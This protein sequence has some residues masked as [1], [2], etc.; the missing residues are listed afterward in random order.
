MYLI[1]IYHVLYT[2]T[3]S[4]DW[5]H[6]HLRFGPFPGQKVG[7]LLYFIISLCVYASAYLLLVCI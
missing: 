4:F 2:A 1:E 6:V 7:Q 3:M 5:L